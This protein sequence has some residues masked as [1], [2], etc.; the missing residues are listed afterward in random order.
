MCASS[1]G[2]SKKIKEYLEDYSWKDVDSLGNGVEGVS[3]ANKGESGSVY[4][5]GIDKLKDLRKQL[6]SGKKYQGT[7]AFG[8]PVG[9][10]AHSNGGGFL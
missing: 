8:N 2:D 10:V 5:K 6:P 3:E 9:N 4:Q 1:A 7:D